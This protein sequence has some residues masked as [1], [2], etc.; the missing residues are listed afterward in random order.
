[1]PTNTPEMYAAIARSLPLTRPGTPARLWDAQ[2]E[3]LGALAWHG[4]LV[5]QLGCGD[6]KGLVSMLG[7]RVVGAQRPLVLIPSK[8]RGTYDS[9]FCKFDDLG[10][11]LP[12]NIQVR[13][14]NYISNHS[15]FLD[16]FR[17]DYVFIDEAHNFRNPDSARTTRLMRSLNE[18]T[19]RARGGSVA[20]CVASG[21]L[22][23]KS[24][25]DCAHL[26]T[27]AVGR[28]TPMPRH[29]APR[30]GLTRE[31]A[32]WA[33]CLDPDGRAT[34]LDWHEMRPLVQYWA[35]D[36]YQRYTR[37]GSKERREIVRRAYSNRRRSAPGVVV[38]DADSCGIPLSIVVGT[39]PRPPTNVQSLMDYAS[40]GLDPVS[41]DPF[42]DDI[43]RWRALQQ[44]SIGCYYRWNWGRVGRSRPD[45]QWL[46]IRSQWNRALA[47]ELRERS[48]P[49]YDSPKYVEIA[50]KANPLHRLYERWARWQVEKCKYNIEE[51]RE[52]ITIDPWY[53]R[54]VVATA[55]QCQ[56]PTI[57]WYSSEGMERA[58]QAE[59]LPCYGAGSTA[60]SRATT[61]GLS[62]AR[63]G[64]GSNLQ[65]RWAH[66]L[67][68]EFPSSGEMA[69]QVIAR[70]HRPGQSAP[71]VNL[72]LWCHTPAFRKN[73]T[74]ARNRAEF[75]DWAQGRQRLNYATITEIN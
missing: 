75:I 49:D 25:L 43:A 67:F 6:G 51:L 10:F 52:I 11:D 14:H 39:Q 62:M 45:E 70:L 58:L 38:S 64:T 50:V 23:A 40:Q 4:G 34:V 61:C 30:D 15:T 20:F 9:E 5:A 28:H 33:R 74:T 73:L 26:M 29:P 36:Y 72:G 57:V 32:C 60:P 59:G 71:A 8:L 31:L 55:R 21:T 24:I 63:H 12:R 17:P 13:S 44:L 2:A 66:A 37:C 18:Y 7:A 65:D 41:G 22:V 48:G 46:T 68:G 42:I 69:E 16:E 47:R 3:A 56:A 1:M 54:H 27:H 53:A 19:T 35:P